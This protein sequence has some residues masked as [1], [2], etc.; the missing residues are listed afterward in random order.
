[1]AF[2]NVELF[3]KIATDA[4][5]KYGWHHRDEV[6]LII[7]SE[8]AT[9]MVKNKKTGEKDGVLRISRPGYHTMDE[10]NSEMAWLNQINEYTPLIVANPIRGKDGENV[11]IVKDLDG[12]KYFCVISEYLPGE[13]P[14]ENNEEQMVKQFKYLGEATAY[15]HRQTRIWNGASKLIRIEWTYDTIIGNHAAWGSWQDFPNLTSEAE[16]MFTEVSKIIEKRLNRYGKNKNNYGLIHADLRLANLLIEGNQ[17]KVIDF[18]DCGFGWHLQDFASALSFIEEKAIVSKLVNAW[19]HGYKKVLPFTDTD[20]QEIDTFIMMRRLQLTA[21]LASH[22]E[23]GP[24]AELS[25]GWMEGTMELAERYL[26]LF[27]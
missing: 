27:A 12:K 24:V 20:F 6:S 18:D 7:L 8:N 16:M 26:K 1:M 5:E 19:L 4:L 10:L 22:K 11:Q 15:L 2:E 14:D 9:Y 3:D 21:W 25:V 17:I 23:S 13:S